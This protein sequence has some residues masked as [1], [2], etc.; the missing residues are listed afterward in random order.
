[1]HY[2]LEIVIDDYR[3]D[4]HWYSHFDALACPPWGNVTETQR[5]LFPHPPRVSELRSRP[6]R[7]SELAAAETVLCWLMRHAAVQGSTRR[8]TDVLAVETINTLNEAFCAHQAA[9]CPGVG[10]NGEYVRECGRVRELAKEVRQELLR[11]ERVPKNQAEAVCKYEER[12][13]ANW[14]EQVRPL[15]AADGTCALTP[16]L[17]CP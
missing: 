17:Q 4:K 7:A 11:M 14:A 16:A 12:A 8:L 9:H 2:G 6:V 15:S 13:C 3:Y 1:M 10:D 5:G